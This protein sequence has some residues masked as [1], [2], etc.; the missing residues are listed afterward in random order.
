VSA[1]S[2]LPGSRARSYAA[3]G[4]LGGAALVLIAVGGLAPRT[5]TGG[6]AAVVL[7]G[8]DVSMAWAG[9]R[10]RALRRGELPWTSIAQTL[11]ALADGVQAAEWLHLLY[12]PVG[13]LRT[14]RVVGFEA[15]LRWRS[16]ALGAVGP[17]RFV[18]VAEASGLIV[19]IGRWVLFQATRGPSTWRSSPRASS[20]PTSATGC[21]ERCHLAQGWLFSRPLP[22]ADAER[23]LTHPAGAVAG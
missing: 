6:L 5:A 7:A 9:V 12:Q 22:A 4:A 2:P 17:D 18:P 19:P 20:A 1:T 13:D 10:R 21:A 15:L 8:G 16:P 23:L 14:E 3:R 11:A